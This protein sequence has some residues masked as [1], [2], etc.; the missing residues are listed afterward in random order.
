MKRA[1]AAQSR[2]KLFTRDIGRARICQPA[3][4]D[5]VAVAKPVVEPKR[6]LVAI[7]FRHV[8][9]VG[10][11]IVGYA[12]NRPRSTIGKPRCGNAA[13]VESGACVTGRCRKIAEKHGCQ[14]ARAGVL[15]QLPEF[16]CFHKNVD[17]RIAA[18]EP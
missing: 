11:A 13:C 10:E 1:E 12:I 9:K 17:L 18:L 14:A 3:N 2:H 6:V 15:N 8:R 4:V 5:V 7:C 16:R